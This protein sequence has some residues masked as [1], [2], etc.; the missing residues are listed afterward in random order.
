MNKFLFAASVSLLSQF[1]Y[2]EPYDDFAE[3]SSTYIGTCY[4]L[5]Y[6]KLQKCPQA[7]ATAP[8]KCIDNVTSL[9]PS[10]NSIQFARGLLQVKEQLKAN[11]INGIRII[12]KAIIFF[13]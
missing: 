9:V 4:G 8:N 5:E 3:V 10:S 11:A 7:S 2:A 6:L 13:I 1:S 12:I